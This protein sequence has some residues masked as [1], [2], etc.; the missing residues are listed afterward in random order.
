MMINKHSTITHMYKTK[1]NIMQN[2]MIYMHSL[3]I[4]IHSTN[5]AGVWST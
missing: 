5:Q 2:N 1:I 4:H 3:M